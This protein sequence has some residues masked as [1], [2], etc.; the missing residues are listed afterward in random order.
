MTD[1]LSQYIPGKS[2]FSSV[3]TSGAEKYLT[4]LNELRAG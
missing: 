1:A 2:E 4:A 3:V